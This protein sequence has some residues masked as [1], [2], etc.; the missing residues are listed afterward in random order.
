MRNKNKLRRGKR[1]TNRR[2]KAGSTVQLTNEGIRRMESL[3]QRSGTHTCRDCVP[4]GLY[5]IGFPIE[6]FHLL[7]NAVETDKGVNIDSFIDKWN[8]YDETRGCKAGKLLCSGLGVTYK[9]WTPRQLVFPSGIDVTT[10]RQRRRRRR[11][12]PLYSKLWTHDPFENGTYKLAIWSVKDVV[13]DDK[14]VTGI[15][16]MLIGKS[17]N[18]DPYIY[19]PQIFSDNVKKHAGKK[20][21]YLWK[22]NYLRDFGSNE[23]GSGIED[24]FRYTAWAYQY[25]AGASVPNGAESTKEQIENAYHHSESYTIPPIDLGANRRALPWLWDLGRLDGGGTIE[26]LPRGAPFAAT[27]LPI[28]MEGLFPQDELRREISLTAKGGKRKTRKKHAKRHR[29]TKRK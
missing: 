29:K 14:I 23:D 21:R 3:R 13:D 19:D 2:K 16:V 9:N 24:Y 26:E 15:H 5:N 28:D 22:G 18:G 10:S 20:L 7:Q 4:S 27:G 12:G 25:L 8:K 6:E 17:R 11:D 1:K